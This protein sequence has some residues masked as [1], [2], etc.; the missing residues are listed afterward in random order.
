MLNCRKN[1]KDI[2]L[3]YK[4]FVPVL[5]WLLPS[6]I[7]G[8]AKTVYTLFNSDYQL[9]TS[10]TSKEIKIDKGQIV[11]NVLK[12]KNLQP[13]S[14]TIRLSL[15]CPQ[16]WKSIYSTDKQFIIGGN[17]SIFIPVRIIPS[18][19]IKGNTKYYI[20]ALIQ[21][22]EGTPISSEYFYTSTDI[23]SRWDMTVNPSRRIYFLNN[24]NTT[25]FKV[26]L[27]NSGN[28]DQDILLRMSLPKSNVLIMDTTEKVISE[29]KFDM[30]LQTM[31][32]TNFFFKLKFVEGERNFKNIDLENYNP[33]VIN[34]ERRFSL[35]FHSDEPRRV[36]SSRFSRSD[37]IDFIKLPNSN[38]INPYGS[39]VLP[40]TAYLRITN[41]LDDVIFSSLHLRGNKYL[42][43]GGNL[44]YNASMYFSSQENFY[45]NDS[46]V[47]DIPWY[48]GYFDRTKN[49]QIGYI[50]SGTIG[51]QTSGKGIKGEIEVIPNHRV[52]A[53][54]IKS[55]YFF[56]TERLTSWGL[57]HKVDWDDFSMTTRYAHSEH[58]VAKLNTDVISVE[59]KIRIAKKHHLSITGA[60]SNRYSYIDPLNKYSK[61]GYLAGLGYTSNFFKNTWKFN[62][63]GS[64]TSKGFG[65]YGFERWFLNHR[66]RVK[67]NKDIEIGIVNNYNHYRY[68]EEHYNY[69]PGLNENYY[70]FNSLNFYSARYLPGV[71]PGLFY[72]IRNQYGSNFH[73]RGLN[74]S[75]N[76]YEINKNL[77]FSFISTFGLSRVMNVPG[78]KNHFV[79]K[80]N[81]M[82]RHKNI[83]INGFYIY[84]PLSPSMVLMK[85]TTHILPQNLRISVM[86]QYLFP[87]KHLVLQ[88][89]G[90]YMYTNVYNHH[91]FSL[92]PEL[93]YFTNSGWRFSINPSYTLYTSKF[94]ITNIDLPSYA[95]N[96]E[97]EFQRHTNDNFLVSIGIRKDFGIP[98]PTTYKF[99]SDIEFVAFYDL[100][101]N[102]VQDENEPG[103]ENV[104][105]KTGNWDVITNSFG[106]ATLL[107]AEP[108][109]FS[110]DVL[111]LIDLK[112][113]FPLVNDSLMVFNDEKIHIPFVKGVKI[114][115]S[116][117]L[118]KENIGAPETKPFDLSGIK[119]I[120]VNGIDYQTLTGPDGAFEFYL[121]FGD[122]VV[123]LD[124]SILNGRYYLLKN[125]FELNLDEEIENMYITFHILEKKRKI[126]VKKFSQDGEVKE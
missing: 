76:K 53:F 99:Y 111:P 122:Y 8:Q 14:L 49:I 16:Y 22:A 69:V 30:S 116:V 47:R 60:W 43:N 5:L 21:N 39:D 54:Y 67:I 4:L 95:I 9:E 70:F 15:S 40:L 3:K 114:F 26:N 75:Y 91:S 33:S 103:I 55:P 73:V 17:D 46:Y 48:V 120:A 106:N 101:G 115:G 51:I 79:Y 123:S 25:D 107:N 90:S 94:K 7:F 36:G 64:Y 50:N 57:H 82:I 34:Q 29:R 93:Y 74:L 41:I 38:K 80:L 44:I 66:T 84:G 45:K 1:I 81:T 100:N 126:R 72:D 110:F 24:S 87:G 121:P 65:A 62:I 119:I 35:Y 6:I 105:I 92:S 12:I 104:V 19:I 86:H 96:N 23:I 61:E 108:G 11:S 56:T 118:E 83:S 28:E 58:H 113:W 85:E 71:K 20:N 125:N 102:K 124:E 98:I 77:Q 32:D 31:A 37:K 59:P 109:K 89:T 10:F 63:R 2:I 52:G 68:D 112:G 97:F 78:S 42:N 13:D 27:F 117:F 88:T 18:A